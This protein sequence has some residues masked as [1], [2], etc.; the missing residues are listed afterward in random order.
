[1]LTAQQFATE[2]LYSVQCSKVVVYLLLMVLVNMVD[3]PRRWGG[4]MTDGH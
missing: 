2:C 1:M 3:L 4:S